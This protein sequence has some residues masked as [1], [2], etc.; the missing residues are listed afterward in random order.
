MASKV[1]IFSSLCALVLTI[2]VCTLST[3]TCIA[4]NAQTP[5]KAAESDYQFT[6]PA[7]F[8]A[9]NQ[10]NS[11]GDY[12]IYFY[13]KDG[14]LI[15]V[16]DIKTSG[17]N[18]L[19]GD[20]TIGVKGGQQYNSSLY[21]NGHDLSVNYGKLTIAY[22]GSTCNGEDVYDV[23]GAEWTVEN[24]GD[25]TTYSFSGQV[26]GL[27]V[28][29]SYYQSCMNDQT[30]CDKAR[31]TLTDEVTGS[32]FTCNETWSFDSETGVL[33][34]SGTGP[35]EDY[36][37]K[38]QPW[39][40]LSESIT[41]VVLS[42]GVTSIGGYAFSNCSSLTSITIP[43]SVTSIGGSAFSNCSSLT[44]ITIP[45]SVTSIGGYA[46][47]NC[48][49]LTSIN[50]PNSV[51]SIGYYAFEDCSSL[52]SITIPNS[53]T[54]IG[55]Y[56]FRG[57][58]SLPVIDNIRYADTYLVEP[59]NITLSTFSIK[60]GTRWIGDYAFES[61]SSLTSITIPKSVTSIGA[62][63]FDNCTNLT[64]IKVDDNNTAYCDI[65]GVLFDKTITTLIQYPVGK[66]DH[67]Y[68][69]P[70]S[71]TSIGNY[72]FYG[73][74][75]LTSVT[76]PN[77]ITT[78]GWSAF[79]NCSGLTSV[80]IPNSVTSIERNAFA[81]CSGLTSI[82]VESENTQYDSRKNCNAIIE[83]ETNT[84]IVGC[85]NTII[86]N[87]V[88]SIGDWAFTNCI[89]LTS[90]TIPNSVKSI[91]DWAF[92]GC[93]LTSV[94]IPNGVTSIGDN[95]FDGIPNI[96]YNG[97]AT[98]SPWGAKCVNGYVDG[99]FVYKNDLKTDLVA[100]S[101]AATGKIEIPNSVTSIGK[102][103]FLNCRDITSI[104]IP[105]SVTT[106]GERAF[107]YCTGLT[108]VTIGN[109]VTSIGGW[110]FGGCN[111]LKEVHI[112]DIEK[113]C[114]IEFYSNSSNPVF[115]SKNL[116]IGDVLVQDLVIPTG[117]TS[118]KKY[119]FINCSNL[120]SVTIPNSVTNIDTAA[121]YACST[122]HSIEISNSVQNIEYA[123]FSYCSSL[124]SVIIPES[125]Q[126]IGAYPFYGC[127]NLTSVTWN[128]INCTTYDDGQ[129]VYSP[130]QGCENITSF[131]IGENVE[132]LPHGLCYGLPITSI[133]IPNKVTA[134]G[135][136]AF[137]NCSG[138]TS[139]T[140]PNSVT[141]IGEWAF[142]DCSSLT[143]V[144][145]GNSVSSIGTGAFYG[146]SSLT[147]VTIP[148]SVSTI[149]MGG[150]FQGC[151]A[152]TEVHWNAVNC[153]VAP[154]D[155][156]N[157]Y[158]Y[159][160]LGTENNITSFTLGQNVETIPALLCYG[161][162]HL[163]SITIPSKVTHIGQYAFSNCIGLTSITS[164]AMTPPICSEGVFD[165]VDK[166]IPLYVPNGRV[167]AYKAAYG[168]K[169]FYNIQ[170]ISSTP[171]AIEETLQSAS[172]SINANGDTR[173]VFEN[174][175][176]YLLLPNG[177]RYNLQGLEIK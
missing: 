64:S 69:I 43:N 70:E 6:S 45:N 85:Q 166:S 171:S 47:S 32:P 71:V 117:V 52:T 102:E 97:S 17:N 40:A 14:K 42:D 159:S 110:A 131:T 3:V 41:S 108:S 38:S 22:C 50:I 86:P 39:E 76:I 126:T 155:E 121:F 44:S 10:E 160:L 55:Y 87:S 91:G 104:T 88:A 5:Q 62:G 157:H 98:G 169:D 175:Q 125:L 24:E 54:S 139:V 35:M 48:S 154:Y 20:Y 106:I 133:V 95:A 12:S 132:S 18:S 107:N 53:V 138:L 51:T 152:L 143:S 77:S 137:Y 130:F 72:A 23:A 28:W 34:I 172:S 2:S 89:G 16:A 56:A 161:L 96:V 13:D 92:Y 37:G 119:A 149:G 148:E 1:T 150:T 67:S 112:S 99:W 101:S 151:T 80:T 140:L 65:N 170:A 36:S 134:I 127:S 73:C 9:L 103:T 147:S 174:G 57:C 177:T 153:T 109:S 81:G 114:A 31:I 105:N 33:T 30:G 93:G 61:C 122:L 113:W 165:D 60:E 78:I 26:K 158:Y 15:I 59:V 82:I 120:T 49:S 146:C 163:A 128:A 84:L 7:D 46:F 176:I 164:E 25:V 123:A 118:I 4:A 74:S 162:S 79:Y 19:A 135:S 111:G 8:I 90:I 75:S 141:S 144:T 100:C 116:Y 124:S 63:A 142:Q 27:A 94:T 136:S 156:E 29:K 21:A 173:K 115:Y 58:Y 145:I 168:W 167:E 11:D 66:T 83:T 129:Y 68:S